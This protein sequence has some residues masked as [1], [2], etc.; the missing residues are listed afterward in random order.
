MLRL[1]QHF[2]RACGWADRTASLFCG[3]AGGRVAGWKAGVKKDFASTDREFA[4]N[5]KI[6]F[7]TPDELFLAE[8][9]CTK[10]EHEFDPRTVPTNLP[11]YTPTSQPLTL[12]MPELIIMVG[13]PGKSHPAGRLGCVWN[14]RL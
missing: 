12:E 11:L 9:A 3:D 2:I 1:G 8:P 10:F 13:W 7:H 4:L 6:Q 5:L 14:Q